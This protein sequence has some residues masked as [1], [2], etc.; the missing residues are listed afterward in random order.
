MTL[1]YGPA[2]GQHQNGPEAYSHPLG[3]VLQIRVVLDAHAGNEPSAITAAAG[4]QP[5]HVPP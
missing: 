2:S 3:A 5:T 1:G 4:T